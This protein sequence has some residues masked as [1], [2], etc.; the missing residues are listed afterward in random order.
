MGL[1]AELTRGGGQVSV[2]DKEECQLTFHG[3]YLSFAKSE[4]SYF[5]FDRNCKKRQM[6]PLCWISMTGAN[7]SACSI[8]SGWGSS[9]RLDDCIEEKSPPGILKKKI[10]FSTA[11]NLGIWTHFITF[12]GCYRILSARAFIWAISQC[13]EKIVHVSKTRL[14][15]PRR[16]RP[17]AFSKQFFQRPG[18]TWCRSTLATLSFR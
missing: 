2:K 7:K 12:K 6:S 4:I 15:V 13:S 5:Q 17:R 16:R 11:N 9:H 3:K 1:G 14:K 18:P 10:F 8:S